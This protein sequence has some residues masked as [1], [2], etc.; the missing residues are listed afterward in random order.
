MENN[1]SHKEP[2]AEKRAEDQ[3]RSDKFEKDIQQKFEELHGIKERLYQIR[4]DFSQSEADIKRDVENLASEHNRIERE[5]EKL[6]KEEFSAFEASLSLNDLGI[7]K[8]LKHR[9]GKDKDERVKIADLES[10]RRATVG[11]TDEHLTMDDNEI[12]SAKL[13]KTKSTQDVDK[14]DAQGKW[15]SLFSMF[16]EWKFQTGVAEASRLVKQ[17]SQRKLMQEE[18]VK[19]RSAIYAL[20][21]RKHLNISDQR[22]LDQMTKTLKD[23]TRQSVQFEKETTELLQEELKEADAKRASQRGT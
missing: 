2:S 10:D 9:G 23:L 1:S 5:I 20:R 7:S 15:Q 12:E 16:K 8:I 14:K 19:L 4:Y 17:S 11:S 22:L 6:R 3:K 13:M 21:Q 18:I